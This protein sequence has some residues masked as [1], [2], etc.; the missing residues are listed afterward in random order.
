MCRAIDRRSFLK[1]TGSVGAGLGLA[2]L[3][4]PALFAAKAC[5][6]TPHAE[7]L[8]WRVACCAYTFNHLPFAEAVEKT[9]A[10][11]LKCIEGFAWQPL[12]KASDKVQTNEAMP[13]E[14]R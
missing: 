7:K 12:S 1:V 3:G 4:V 6:G 9:A 13:A 11:G 14:A 5:K 8:G 2:G 10:L